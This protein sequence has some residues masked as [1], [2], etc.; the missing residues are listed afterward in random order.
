VKFA[1]AD[2]PYLGQGKLYDAHHAESRLWDSPEEHRRLV[3]RLVAEFPDGWAM[4]ASSPSL[5]VVL[6][7]CPDDR[8]V[9][10]WLKPFSVFKRGVRP[11]YA[12]EQPCDHRW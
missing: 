7:M 12:E 2:P 10:A 1:Y 11:A 6:P 5:R 4:S 9:A 3:H 8:R